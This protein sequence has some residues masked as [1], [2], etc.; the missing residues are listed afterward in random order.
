M[1]GFDVRWLIWLL[2]PVLAAT[3]GYWLGQ[4]TE[5]APLTTSTAGAEPVS[6]ATESAAAVPTESDASAAGQAPLLMAT[7]TG[8]VLVPG[9]YALESDARVQDLIEAGGGL[10]DEAAIEDINIAAKVVD[11]SVL[12]IP[13]RT[14]EARSEGE[15]F[16]A[17]P[18]ARLNPPAYTRSGWA[19]PPEGAG[20]GAAG[21]PPASGLID[22][23][24]A[25]QAQ[26]E[27]LPGV[28]PVTAGK[29]I[30]YRSLTPFLRVDDMTNIHGIGEK[31]LE[32]LRPLVT[33]R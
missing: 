30:E 27:T 16:L 9:A 20:A 25:S 6:V 5:S 11:G 28:G 32:T 13:K 22:L 2:V 7:V 3:G 8:A 4:R 21:S 12:T 17:Q 24:T 29:I 26:L 10:H 31:T 19:P 33:V 15:T 23:N 18:A 1:L 14:A